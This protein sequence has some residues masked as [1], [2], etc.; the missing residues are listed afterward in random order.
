MSMTTFSHSE[1]KTERLNLRWINESDFED[2]F[3][4]RFHDEVLK[5]VERD[6]VIDK[7]EIK[8]LIQERLNDTK[9]GILCYWGIC[10]KENS[11]LMGTICLWNIDRN[12]KIAEIGYEM[13]PDF[14]KNGYM[15]EALQIVI[16]YG[17]HELKLNIIEAFTHKQNDASKALLCR[18]NFSLEPQRR[19]IGFPNN[20]I[21]TITND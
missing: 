5:Y 15:S 4:I 11:E 12:K 2:I 7:K 10:L 18:N 14:H 16:H 3:K 9:T 20:R 6:K 8:T 19:D 1:L 13:H 17:F 21:Y